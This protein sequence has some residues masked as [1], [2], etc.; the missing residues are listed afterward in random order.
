MNVPQT[1]KHLST[2]KPLLKVT[3]PCSDPGGDFSPTKFSISE[4]QGD[5]STSNT[6]YFL[7][8]ASRK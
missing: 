1:F 3:L 4:R 6:F 7:K 5:R 8:K 2:W